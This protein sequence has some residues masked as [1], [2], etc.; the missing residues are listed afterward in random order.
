ML[1]NRRQFIESTAVLGLA[2]LAGCGSRGELAFPELEAG[3]RPGDLARPLLRK[4]RYNLGFYSQWLSQGGE[5]S[6]ERLLQLAGAFVPVIGG[7]YPE[8]MEEMEEIAVGAGMK[9][10]EIVL[11]NARTDIYAIVE[12]SPRC[13]SANFLTTQHGPGGPEAVDLEISSD[14]V[15]TLP[16]TAD[17]LIHTN[18]FLSPELAE[19]CT[20]GRGP[21]TMGRYARAEEVARGLE[22]DTIPPQSLEVGL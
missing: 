10:E 17:R 8:M 13:A 7:H 15:A 3:G 11:I 9:T 6:L 19:G 2:G 16:R 20:S 5:V 12:S 4:I 21:S 1:I 22:Q 18:H 14:T